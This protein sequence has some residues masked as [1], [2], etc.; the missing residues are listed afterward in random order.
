[1]P[2]KDRHDGMECSPVLRTSS[3]QGC[4][5]VGQSVCQL[6]PGRRG[7]TGVHSGQRLNM[8]RVQTTD[9]F[10]DQ[11]IEVDSRAVA[12]SVRQDS[13]ERLHPLLLERGPGSLHRL[14]E[15]RQV[16]PVQRLRSPSLFRGRR[17]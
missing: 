5:K 17:S 8:R 11:R 1:M 9:G 7:G 4:R 3:R 15:Q 6:G 13:P 12:E 16:P 2:L 14:V 10:D